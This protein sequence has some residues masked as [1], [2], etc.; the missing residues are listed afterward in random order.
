MIVGQ[1]YRVD[2]RAPTCGCS[3]CRTGTGMTRE[4]FEYET[5]NA[6]N[7]VGAHAVSTSQF[8]RKLRIT[9]SEN[10]PSEFDW[11]RVQ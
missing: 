2:F 10:Q 8:P 9:V 3:G 6:C 1:Y 7:G 11:L 4:A 5:T